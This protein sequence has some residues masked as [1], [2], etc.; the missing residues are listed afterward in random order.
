MFE[1][2]QPTVS[3]IVKD[4]SL[5][6]AKNL[7]TWVKFLQA[8]QVNLHDKLK[9]IILNLEVFIIKY[10]KLKNNN[11]R[12]VQGICVADGG[13][14][15]AQFIYTPH[16]NPITN[17][18]KRYNYAHIR[19]RNVIERVNG[20]L[21]SRFSCLSRKL[22]TATTTS[23]NIIVACT[24]ILIKMNHSFNQR[25][26]MLMYLLTMEIAK[27]IEKIILNTKAF[28]VLTNN[29]NCKNIEFLLLYLRRIRNIYLSIITGINI[30]ALYT[31]CKRLWIK[32]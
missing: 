15:Q 13:Y 19:T 25:Q 7:R 18:Q 27:A 32:N 26:S 10:F 8:N 20:L 24:W 4:I 21:K 30:I 1:L 9:V 17:A 14:A 12:T 23:S 3:R 22:G 5:K 29:S 28:K 6:I 31:A 11:F 2:S 16:S